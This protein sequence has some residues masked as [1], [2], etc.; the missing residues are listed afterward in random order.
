MEPIIGEGGAGGADLVKDATTETFMADVID[1][2]A[3]V[4]VILDLWADWC[5]PCKQLGPVLEAAVRAANGKVKLVKLDV[6]K[7]PEIAQQ[8]RVQSIPAVFAFHQGQPVDGFVGALPESQIKAFVDKVIKAGGGDAG[9]DE[10]FAQAKVAFDADNFEAA[11]TIC[12]QIFERDASH[13]P[14]VGLLA[15]C[16]IAAGEL[17]DAAELLDALE[18]DARADPEIAGALAALDLARQAGSVG[19]NAAEFEARIAADPGDHQARYDLGLV[20]YSAGDHEGAADALLDIIA[21]N[22]DWNE[23]AA[24]AKLLELFEAFGADDDVTL[25]GRR[26]LSSILFS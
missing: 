16:H 6:D 13:L 2:S 24:K 21:A 14:T 7:A 11:L 20:R 25:A 5:G 10:A 15:R 1:A 17:D 26:R 23:G 8:L 22:R 3:E 9:I 18:E 12:N 19:G 4:P